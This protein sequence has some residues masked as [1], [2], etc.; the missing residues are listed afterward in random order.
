VL[1]SSSE[2]PVIGLK[3]SVKAESVHNV[4]LDYY[5]LMIQTKYSSS[6]LQMVKNYVL[7][8][9]EYLGSGD[10]QKQCNN[11]VGNKMKGWTLEA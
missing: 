8:S 11:A 3:I 6:F 4:Q 10:G 1:E 9:T 5:L 2:T 7:Q